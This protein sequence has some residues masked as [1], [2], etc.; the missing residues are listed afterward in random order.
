MQ[1]KPVVLFDI[2]DTLFDTANFKNSGLSEYNIYEE[3]AQVLEDLRSVAT[4]G[5]FSKGETQ[6][7][8]TKLENTGLTKFFKEENVH[9][10]DDKNIN[11]SKTINKYKGSK[12]FLIDDILYVLNSAKTNAKN[13]FTIWLK[14]GRYAETQK[15]ISGFT[16]D[17]QVENLLEVGRIVKSNL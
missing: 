7:Q 15:E 8:K 11:L 13:I 9:V 17:A 1:T 10:F 14:R 5:I 16:P 12:I 2:D 6:F 4:L 3:V